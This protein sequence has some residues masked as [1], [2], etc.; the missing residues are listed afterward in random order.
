MSD[1][2]RAWLLWD[3][4]DLVGVHLTAQA[5]TEARDR[6]L[7]AHLADFPIDADILTAAAR[8]ELASFATCST[9]PGGPSAGASMDSL[10]PPGSVPSDA[11]SL[12]GVGSSAI[13]GSGETS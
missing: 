11:G 4:G 8:I 3:A 9:R 10:D 13:E 6:L 1:A 7:A 5:A 12:N 2:L